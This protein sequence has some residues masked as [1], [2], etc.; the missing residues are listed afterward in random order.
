MSRPCPLILGGMILC[1]L[2]WEYVYGRDGAVN[3]GSAGETSI[4][5][6]CGLLNVDGVLPYVIGLECD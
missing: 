6:L 1:P 2:G 4:A 3:G 5:E